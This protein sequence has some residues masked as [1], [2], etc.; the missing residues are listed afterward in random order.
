MSGQLLVRPAGAPDE[1]H[2]HARLRFADGGPELRFVDQRTFGGI[3]LEPLVDD[4]AGGR[5]P[6]AVAHIARDP[7]D[8]AFDE[9]AFVRAL[10]RR[11][12]EVK[13]ALLD[14]SLV[15]GIGNIYA[16][17]ALWRSRMHWATPTER[18][19]PARTRALLGHARDVMREALEVGGTSFDALYVDVTGERGYF[20]R[21]LAVYGR[22]GL[23]CPRCGTPLHRDAFAGRS[24][25]RCPRCQRRAPARRPADSR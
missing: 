7:L 8:P 23:P 12:T 19:T 25:Y 1:P 24:S 4:G 11:R 18:L 22:Q 13:R 17:E 2:L 6:A 9:A 15:S 14:Q 21:E 3:A 10:R 16:D 5:V 20:A